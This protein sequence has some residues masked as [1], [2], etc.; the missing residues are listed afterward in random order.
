[1]RWPLFGLRFALTRARTRRSELLEL[2]VRSTGW[3]DAQ[4]QVFTLRKVYG[5]RPRAIARRLHL[6]DADVERHLIAAARACGRHFLRGR[7]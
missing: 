4:R 3:P 7:H 6:S 5:L 2:A 1:M